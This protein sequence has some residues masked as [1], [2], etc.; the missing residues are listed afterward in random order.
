MLVLIYW[1]FKKVTN[2]SCI[3]VDEKI[4]LKNKFRLT[5][6]RIPST[7]QHRQTDWKRENWKYFQNNS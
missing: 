6:I 3:P 7:S 2:I 1:A 4:G 5:S